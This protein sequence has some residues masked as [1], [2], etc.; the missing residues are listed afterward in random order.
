[1]EAIAEG[2]SQG[3][4]NNEKYSYIAFNFLSNLGL[5]SYAGGTKILVLVSKSKPPAK[6]NSSIE[7]MLLESEPCI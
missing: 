7:S 4:I 1:M 2:P 6:S 5:S 3:S